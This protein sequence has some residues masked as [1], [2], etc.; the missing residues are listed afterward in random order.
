MCCTY[1][2]ATDMISRGTLCACSGV[3]KQ[4]HMIGH[5][6]IGMQPAVRSIQCLAQPVEI[7]EPV[8]I[9]EEAGAT[10]VPPLHNV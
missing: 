7:R 5:Q 9:V 3:R 2:L 1:F 4:V 10:V 8:L 6:Y